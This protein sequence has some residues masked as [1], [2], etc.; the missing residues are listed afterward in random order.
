MNSDTPVEL[1][2]IIHLGLK[3]KRLI[4]WSVC[5]CDSADTSLTFVKHMMQEK[6]LVIILTVER[7]SREIVA[8]NEGE[9]HYNLSLMQTR[10][11]RLS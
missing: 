8:A 1:N 5:C 10:A 4:K 7:F 2:G 11:K 3:L 9:C 6:G